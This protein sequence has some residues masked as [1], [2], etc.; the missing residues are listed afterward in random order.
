MKPVAILILWFS[1]LSMYSQ[2]R[3]FVIHDKSTTVTILCDTADY[4]TVRLAARLLARDIERITGHRPVI[5]R[6][7]AGL[8]GN[9][10]IIGSR[11]SSRLIQNPAI[12]KYINTSALA[13][14]WETY[15]IQTIRK[16]LS[17]ISNALV[18][19]GSDRRGTAYGVFDIAE[20]IGISPWYWWADVTPQRKSKLSIPFI[21]FV[22]NPPSVKYRGIFLNDEDWGLQP[23]AAKTFEPE[24]GDIGPKT[25]AKIFELLLRLKANLI[26]PAMHPCTKAFYH[27]PENRKVADLYGIVVG[28]SHAEPMLRNNVDEWDES[29]MGEYNYFTN[30]ET[31][32]TYWKQRAEE[33]KH[34][35]NIYTVGMRGIHDS[36]MEG[37]SDIHEK[38]AV[39]EK[40]FTDQREIIKT[41]IASDITRIP[42]AFIPYK[43]VLNVYDKGLELP[44]DITIVWPDDNYG[45][46]QRLSNDA[47]QKRSGGA[48]IYYHLS[49]WGRPHDYLWLSSTHPMLLWEE[50]NKAYTTRNNRMWVVNVGDIKPLEYSMNLFLDM[51]YD[52]KPFLSSAY[53]KVHL[54]KWMR[55]I[56]GSSSA[57]ELADVTWQYYNLAFERRP[58]FMGWSQTE[59][60]TITHFTA[61]NHFYYN[62]EAQKRLDEYNTLHKQVNSIRQKIDREKRDA[63]YELVYYPVRC[64]QLINEKF[65][66]NEKAY[67]YARQHRTSANDFAAAVREAFDSIVTETAYYNTKLANGKWNNMMSME[68][69]DLPVFD[70]P[71]TPAWEGS[72]NGWGICA[73]G[74]ADEQ[75]VSH[76]YGNRLPVFYSW[77]NRSYFIDIFL[78]GPESVNWQATVS[79]PWIRLTKT[80]G[81]LTSSVGKKEERIW[82]SIDHEHLPNEKLVKGTITIK[83]GARQLSVPVQ[84]YTQAP[85]GFSGFVEE[86]KYI[87]LFAA[88]YTGIV[89]TSDAEWRSIDGLGYT[90][91]AM[92]LTPRDTFSDKPA[93]T[94]ASLKYDFYHFS[95]GD[96][97]VKVYCLP[98]HALNANHQMRIAVVIDGAE[99]QVMDYRTFD[100][101]ETWKQNVLSNTAIS[102]AKYALRE[103]G[104]HTLTITALDPGIIIDRI[105]IDFGGLKPGYS[106]VPETKMMEVAK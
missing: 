56:F 18:I 48:G 90:G 41:L 70:C 55:D 72:G 21:N 79:Q 37:S 77:N 103:T 42:Q 89:N 15:Q 24:T 53:V 66:L 28:S 85:D 44:N 10:I 102:S 73:E 23:W 91:K 22:S 65:L 97:E 67:Y 106:A 47:E 99:P 4:A 71:M 95:Q 51:A 46:I 30:R 68:P 64:A 78:T 94:H 83:A 82:V 6:D 86:N 31:I 13:D 60:N 88:N 57:R 105:T 43:E 7:L 61:Y 87:S 63:F 96:A 20:R 39:L 26:W 9:V 92:M 17:T 84:V 80:S 69:R 59:P 29:K 1:W 52:M 32:Y 14:K 75:P 74:D 76:Q 81:T 35:E 45:Y 62:D 34:Y 58:E 3:E 12:T 100:R 11:D 5:Q 2:S 104:K 98:T 101:S 8:K 40:I 16:P 27:Y 19:C 36:G 50:M 33:S 38:I 93:T 25:Y 54:E 49:Y